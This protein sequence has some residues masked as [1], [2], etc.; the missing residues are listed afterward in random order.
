MTLFLFFLPRT[1]II[2][3]ISL[4]RPIVGEDFFDDTYSLIS[5][6]YCF[7]KV[8]LPLAIVFLEPTFP[9]GCMS[10]SSFDES[11]VMLDFDVD[12]LGF[13]VLFLSCLTL[14]E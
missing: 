6:V 11:Y 1:S 3:L 10:L 13:F 4:S 5:V 2:S 12:F 14:I 9:Y 7:I 8:D